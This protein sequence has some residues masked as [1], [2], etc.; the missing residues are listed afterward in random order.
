[1][2]PNNQFQQ[3]RRTTTADNLLKRPKFSLEFN[4]WIEKQKAEDPSMVDDMQTILTPK[5]NR[6]PHEQG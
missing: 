5:K 4:K 6:K 1:M 2:Q 3:R